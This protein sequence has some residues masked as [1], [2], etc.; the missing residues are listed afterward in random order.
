MYPSR[1][2]QLLQGSDHCSGPSCLRLFTFALLYVGHAAGRSS[3]TSASA[4]T[5]RAAGTVHIWLDN[6]DDRF[7]TVN[8]TIGT[9]EQTLVLTVDTRPGGFI[10][11]DVSFALFAARTT[12]DPKASTTFRWTSPPSGNSN[13]TGFD[14]VR[15]SYVSAMYDSKRCE[16]GRE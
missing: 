1:S 3:S 16:I 2:M 14:V 11:A 4:T 15:V 8:V 12:F 5:T 13:G 9:P 7:Y 10:V 6:H